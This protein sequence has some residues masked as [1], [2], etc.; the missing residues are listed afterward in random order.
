MNYKFTQDQ[1]SQE[2]TVDHIN[3][4]DATTII[5]YD[6]SVKKLPNWPNVREV[7]CYGCSNLTELPNWPNVQKVYFPGNQLTELPNWRN[8]QIVNCSN[9]QLE[10]LEYGPKFVRVNYYVWNNKP[11]LQKPENCS[12]RGDFFN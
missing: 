5:I 2:G 3:I 1:V 7:G 10:S 9:N 11:R 4:G 12:I 6:C 8:V